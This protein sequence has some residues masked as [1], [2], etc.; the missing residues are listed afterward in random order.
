MQFYKFL[1]LQIDN[2]K[3]IADI[4]GYMLIFKD[5]NHTSGEV[6]ASVCR[7]IG[8]AAQRYRQ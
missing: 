1:C 6:R 8:A 2:A 7:T 4:G 5:L 3:D